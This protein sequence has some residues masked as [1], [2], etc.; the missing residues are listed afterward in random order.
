[1]T[2]V[3]LCKTVFFFYFCFQKKY[4]EFGLLTPTKYDEFGLLTHTKYICYQFDPSNFFFAASA[5]SILIK[6]VQ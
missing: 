6:C 4:D 3:I 2:H 5:Y 1:M